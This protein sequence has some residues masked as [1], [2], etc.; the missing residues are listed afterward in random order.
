[1][2]KATIIELAGSIGIERYTE[3]KKSYIESRE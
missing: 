1:M 3:Y 2:A